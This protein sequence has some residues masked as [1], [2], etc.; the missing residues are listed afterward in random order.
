M[1]KG[2]TELAWSFAKC[3]VL[4]HQNFTDSSRVLLSKTAA[5]YLPHVAIK[6]ILIL[7]RQK[8][9]GS[10]S[11]SS[12]SLC[13]AR[14]YALCGK[15]QHMEEWLLM[16]DSTSQE[17]DALLVHRQGIELRALSLAMQGTDL[18]TA[19]NLIES[20]MMMHTQ[21]SIVPSSIQTLYGYVLVAQGHMKE[22]L[23]KIK[24]SLT[25][26]SSFLD[27]YLCVK[28]FERSNSLDSLSQQWVQN[29]CTM[30][31]TNSGEQK[32][33]EEIFQIVSF[34]LNAIPLGL[35]C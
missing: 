16:V 3:A 5:A 33:A 6:E 20:L 4:I 13:V 8:Q 18:N 14:T 27:S 25:V 26:N 32:M 28:A 24:E 19:Q 35:A 21:N 17:S 2:F 15:W 22:G 30:I 34:K 12:I 31:P 1:E 29:L 9:N 10:A 7:L 23:A 11:F